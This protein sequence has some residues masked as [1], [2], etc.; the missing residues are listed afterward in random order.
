MK[1]FFR[2]VIGASSLL[3][4]AWLSSAFWAGCGSHEEPQEPAASARRSALPA[5]PA[6]VAGLA[7]PE[8]DLNVPVGGWSAPGVTAEDITAKIGQGFRLHDLSVESTLTPM[9]FTAE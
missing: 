3:I 4:A 7:F 5:T 9:R 1:S 6:N 8:Y 2:R